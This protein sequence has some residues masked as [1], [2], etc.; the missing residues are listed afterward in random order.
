MGDII[1]LP[2]KFVL[3]DLESACELG[4]VPLT[5][6]GH[7]MKFQP[8]MCQQSWTTMCDLVLIGDLLASSGVDELSTDGQQ[9]KNSLQ[10]SEC[11]VQEALDHVWFAD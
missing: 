1:Q 5:P 10:A 2:T 9:L 11:T 7:N 6:V 3:I 8:A 4:Q